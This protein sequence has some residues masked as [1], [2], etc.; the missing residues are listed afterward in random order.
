LNVS[1]GAL[2]EISFPV[3]TPSPSPAPA[4]FPL[5]PPARDSGTRSC[6]FQDP[7]LEIMAHAV[8]GEDAPS[9]DPDRAHSQQQLVPA[10]P[11]SARQRRSACGTV[12]W[13]HCYSVDL[14][15]AV[16]W[17]WVSARMLAPRL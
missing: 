14:V 6:G 10:P 8:W 2:Q 12:L 7:W 15:R 4:G 16:D 3:I 13:L 5:G 1:P 11:V 9:H 17:G